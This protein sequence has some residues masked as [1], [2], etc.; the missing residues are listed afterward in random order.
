ME[1]RL[2]CA[3]LEAPLSLPLAAEEVQF[4]QILAQGEHQHRPPNR[5]FHRRN[6]AQYLTA[7]QTGNLAILQDDDGEW[8]NEALQQGNLNWIMESLYTA[9]YDHWQDDY[10]YVTFLMVRDLGF[11][12]AFYQPVA[13]TT[14][15]I[16]YD[17]I[18]GA[19]KFDTTPD[20]QVEGLI[21]MNYYG[22]WSDAPVVGRYVFGQE[23]GHRWGAFCNVESDGVD[24]GVLLGRDVAH[25]SY[26]LD[27][28]NSPM[29]GNDW[30]DNGD[31][32][33]TNDV[34]SASTYSDLDL[35]LMGLIP[36]DDVGPQTMLLVDEAEQARVGRDPA[37][38]PEVFGERGELTV[39]ATPWGFSVDDIIAAEGPR[40]PDWQ[41]SPKN[42]RMAIV[43]LVLQDDKFSE[44]V[45]G[46]LD[47][48][49][50]RWES[51]WETDVRG[52]ANLDTT[53][54]SSDAPTWGEAVDSGDSGAVD[55]SGTSD[56]G[57]LADDDDGGG[58]AAPAGCG[59]AS[60]PTPL[61]RWSFSGALVAF[62][63]ALARRRR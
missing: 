61:R 57:A 27:T 18:V 46:D 47:G 59:C 5:D 12:A 3:A 22:I 48:V 24:P 30:T 15:G 9:F 16:G 34:S 37:A 10:Q 56:A 26:W 21:F 13:N 52:L 35:Y 17:A 42:F 38:T 63:A 25:W 4:A 51:E 36:S 41:T 44:R 45:I 62:A 33:W 6:G 54:G 39:T 1:R 7:W 2:W 50:T 28:T 55:D 29:E 60:D 49:R 14:K 43:I 40:D 20:T 11:F 32:S 31:G 8:F 23:F 19:E 58:A 53:L